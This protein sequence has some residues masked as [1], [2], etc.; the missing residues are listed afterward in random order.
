MFFCKLFDT[1]SQKFCKK[2]EWFWTEMERILQK[3][4]TRIVDFFLKNIKVTSKSV[5]YF[6]KNWIIWINIDMAKK[7]LNNLEYQKIIHIRSINTKSDQFF[8]RV[9]KHGMTKTRKNLTYQDLIISPLWD[10]WLT[11]CESFWK[12]HFIF[13]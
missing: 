10:F 2:T 1:F 9:F 5:N 12:L 3:F 8:L 7:I 4:Q 11:I 13:I 6:A